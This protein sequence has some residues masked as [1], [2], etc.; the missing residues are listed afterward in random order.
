MLVLGLLSR[1]DV[2]GGD[3]T[4]CSR[5]RQGD[6]VNPTELYVLESIERGKD[7]ECE[8]HKHEPCDRAFQNAV[9]L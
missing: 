1:A 2:D 6:K 9:L 3:A 7:E 5:N 4:Q 8:E